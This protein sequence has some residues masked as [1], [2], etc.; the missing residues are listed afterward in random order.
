M[1]SREKVF[2]RIKDRITSIKMLN[3]RLYAGAKYE[4]GRGLCRSLEDYAVEIENL[5]SK[6]EEELNG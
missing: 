4:Q 6:L 5:I 3:R 1:E 2:F